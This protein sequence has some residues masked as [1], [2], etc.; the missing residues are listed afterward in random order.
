MSCSLI[1]SARCLV[2]LA[3]IVV[4]S[5]AVAQLQQR[6]VPPK[7]GKTV[8]DVRRHDPSVV[9]VK[10][11]DDLSVDA[12]NGILGDKGTGMLGAARA[13]VD[14]QALGR[15]RPMHQLPEAQLDQLRANAEAKLGKEVA[16]LTA[17][18][19][20]DLFPGQDAATVCD[21]LNA[22]DVVDRATPNR[23]PAPAPGF[24][25]Y[26]DDQH[27][28]N[29]ATDGVDAECMWNVP[30]GTG[31]NVAV[32]DIEYS[33]NL[34]HADLPTVTQLSADPTDPFN[35]N[36]HGTAVLGEMAGLD[37]GMG[38][39]GVC[40]GATFYVA[41]ADH[42]GSYDLPQGITDALGTLVAGDFILIE[43][44]TQGPNYIDNTSQFGLVASEWD[45]DVY[46]AI[47]VAVGN[48]VCVVAA[49]GNGSQDLDGPEYNVGHAPFLLANDSGSIIVGA[50]GAPDFA[51]DRQRLNFS[52]YGATVDLQGIGTSVIT[53]GYGDLSTNSGVN[54]WFTGTFGGTSSS[55]P[56]VTGAAAILQSAYFEETGAYLDCTTLRDTLIATGSPQLGDTSENIG[57]RPNAAAAYVLLFPADDCNNNGIPDECDADCDGN[58]IPDECD[59]TDGTWP[60]CNS[61]GIPDVCD[62]DPADPDGDGLVSEDCQPNGIPDECDLDAA[63]PDGNGLVS[64]DCNLNGIPDECD[65]ADG[66]SLD[67][68]L[69][70]IPDECEIWKGST[71][72][73]GPFFCEMNCDPDCNY[74]GIPDECDIADG[75]S[76]DCNGNMIP[77]EC[78]VDAQ[79][80]ALDVDNPTLHLLD[81]DTGATIRSLPLTGPAALG[82]HGLACDPTTGILWCVLRTGAT[83]GD[84]VLGSINMI[85]GAVNVVGNLGDCFD[86]ITFADDGTL[87]GVTGDGADTPERLYTISTADASTTFDRTLGHGSEGEAI[88]W[89]PYDGIIY[90]ASGTGPA[91]FPT[92]AYWETVNGGVTPLIL[93]G[94]DEEEEITG[95]A[96]DI[97]SQGFAATTRNDE[98]VHRS[99][100]GYQS[101]VGGITPHVEGLVFTKPYSLDC[102]GNGVP[103]ECEIASGA[104]QDCNNNGILDDCELEA[105]F[106]P[107]AAEAR[108]F[109]QHAEYVCPGID[110]VGDTFNAESEYLD[111]P[112][113]GIDAVFGCGSRVGLYDV[114][115]KYRPSADGLLFVHVEGPGPGLEWI[116]GIYDDC[117]ATEDGLLDCNVFQHH[118]TISREVEQGVCYWIR[119]AAT[120]FNRGAFT[121]DLIGPGC[122]LNE[123]DLNANGIL[124]DCEC[125]WDVNNDGTV[126]MAD[127][128]QV[129]A[130][131]GQPCTGCAEDVDKDGDVDMDDAQSVFL[132]FG[133]CPE[134]IVCTP[135]GG[136]PQLCATGVP[137]DCYCFTRFDGQ[138]GLCVQ[139]F[140]CAAATPCVTG[141]CPPG[142]VCVTDTACGTVCAPLIGCDG[143]PD[144][145]PGVT[146]VG[147]GA[148]S[149][150]LMA[151]GRF[152]KD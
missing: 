32:C 81:Y 67:C 152:I 46:D 144:G 8:V 26:E 49:A 7:P 108:D 56:I 134:N 14:L 126:D 18:F 53:T 88:A 12:R 116:F 111:F 91:N 87:W 5:S 48:G 138:D 2:G 35:D 89:S 96:Y 77:D 16:D 54:E 52:N 99:A 44:Q 122:V 149:T 37:N 92:G 106:D 70:G 43:Q 78:D 129:V 123:N 151:S 110:Y 11:N 132:N 30:G 137:N 65:I 83:C 75:T 85:T 143:N 117:P 27:Y 141:D 102:N 94:Y 42:S 58:G 71:A 62:V 34:N 4:G 57:P 120:A 33:W 90:H 124:D 73:G 103:D 74:N 61:N 114:W 113:G 131:I 127:F 55:S 121:M 130:A 133:D 86:T 95:L 1:R 20:I 15:W 125:P 118:G 140:N 19:Y 93:D 36:N 128:L 105:E 9:V 115:Y 119:I 72:P 29:P 142:F 107:A 64:A 40:Y 147:G 68:Q 10:F 6:V 50:G 38:V 100:A 79:L 69:N 13:V 41:G 21:A 139:D 80:W 28:I 97:W 109:C 104:A 51:T 135:A 17:S 98:L 145:S 146:F 82:G 45:E 76:E 148:G 24:P 112:G 25:D 3:A 63:D 47:V 66:T 60:D 31:V 39:R 136:G 84:R 101:F 22:L 59:I 23:L 150:G